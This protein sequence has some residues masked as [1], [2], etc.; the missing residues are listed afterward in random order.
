MLQNFK[1]E[2]MIHIDLRISFTQIIL[3]EFNFSNGNYRDSI[4]RNSRI[5]MFLYEFESIY[6][7]KKLGK[8]KFVFHTQSRFMISN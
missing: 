7:E 5:L 8:Y 6:N 3:E 2:N 1:S 4:I